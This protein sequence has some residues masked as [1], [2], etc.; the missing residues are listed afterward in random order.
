[1]SA[2]KVKKCRGMKSG[3]SI[4]CNAELFEVDGAYILIPMP[5][6]RKC[7]IKPKKYRGFSIICDECGYETVWCQEPPRQ[8]S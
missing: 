5:S 7:K 1:M 2:T 6:G 3:S 8:I 4:K